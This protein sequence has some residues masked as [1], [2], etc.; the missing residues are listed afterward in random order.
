[1][2]LTIKRFEDLSLSELYEIIR[3]RVA[4]F[5]VEQTCPYQ[6]CDERDRHAWHVVLHD[7]AG[8]AAYLRVIDANVQCD[9]VAIGR[10]LT[11]RRGVG[12]GS[13]ILKEGIRVAEEKM[14]AQVIEIEAQTYAIPFYEKAGFSQTS[15]EFMEDG[16]PHVKMRRTKAEN[17]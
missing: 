4:V 11:T 1:M 16:I 15:A 14:N 10:V 12:L 17:A 8:I 13:L 2:E 7:E 5:V 6:E 9:A 3:T